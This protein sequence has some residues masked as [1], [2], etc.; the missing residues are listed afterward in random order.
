MVVDVQNGFISPKTVHVV[1]RIHDL[2]RAN[3]FDLTV[4]TQFINVPNS[5]YIEFLGW[6]RLSSAEETA[7]V[8]RLEPFAENAFKKSIYTSISPE[9]LRFLQKNGVQSAYV[10]G[11]DTDCC[12]LQTAVDLFEVG[13]HP[14]VLTY[15]SASNGGEKSHDAALTVLRRSIGEQNL[16]SSA[17]GAGVS[18][19]A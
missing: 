14:Y 7:I 3:L 17:L 15:Y 4:F 8:D 10:C 16:I 19:H 2:L 6:H 12:V 18:Q 13:I 11:I 1:E 9:V 5:P